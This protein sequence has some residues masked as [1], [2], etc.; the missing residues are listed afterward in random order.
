MYKDGDKLSFEVIEANHNHLV[1]KNEKSENEGFLY[2]NEMPKV[3]VEC[4]IVDEDEENVILLTE[5]IDGEDKNVL[6]G[7]TM[8]SDEASGQTACRIIEEH[9][10]LKMDSGDLELYDF[11]TNPGRDRDFVGECYLY[12]SW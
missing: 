3:T 6:P 10:G 8:L 7:G 5:E 1:V 2:A 4:V 9:T 11:R 12:C